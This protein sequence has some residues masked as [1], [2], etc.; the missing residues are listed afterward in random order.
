MKLVL[1]IGAVICGVVL[2]IHVDTGDLRP[3]QVAGVGII[4]A[5]LAHVIP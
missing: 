3:E 5:A 1:V 4:L 2:G